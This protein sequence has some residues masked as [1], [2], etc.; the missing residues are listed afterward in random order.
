MKC[1]DCVSY[2]ACRHMWSCF[3]SVNDFEEVYE[4]FAERCDHFK[5]ASKWVEL[6]CEIGSTVYVVGTKCLSGLWD[7]ECDM[8]DAETDCPCH[9]DNEWIVFKREADLE[10]IAKMIQQ[11]NPN[12]I[13]GK[14]V[15]TDS[16]DAFERLAEI[17]NQ[18]DCGG[19]EDGKSKV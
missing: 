13:F 16:D 2:K 14:T 8:R 12:F 18:N 19:N 5:D 4:N 15:F 10:F 7:Y 3:E 6:P 11:K 9:L 1:K 17:T